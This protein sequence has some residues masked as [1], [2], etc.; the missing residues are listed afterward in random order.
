MNTKLLKQTII[1]KSKK[2]YDFEKL[3]QFQSDSKRAWS[4]MKEIIRKSK[5]ISPRFPKRIIGNTEW[6]DKETR[7]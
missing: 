6:V 4:I 3:L 1:H 7:S 2:I 5:A